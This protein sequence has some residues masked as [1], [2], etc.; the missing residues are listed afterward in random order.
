MKRNALILIVCVFLFSLQGKAEAYKASDIVMVHLQ[1]KTKYVC[2]PDRILSA[3]T[4][5]EM[6]SILYALEQKTGIETV[7][8]AVKEIEGGDCFGFAYELGK[9][10]GV[11]KKKS[12][13]GLVI[14]LST[15]ERCI[16]F[17]TG[18]GLEGILP[19]ALCKRIQE[20]YMNPDFAKGEWDT[21]MLAGIRAIN[22]CLDGSMKAE[23]LAEDDD[24]EAIIFAMVFMPCF[25]IGIFLLV[26]VQ[27]RRKSRCPRCKKH[28]LRRTDVRLISRKN[29]IKREKATY[30]CSHCGYTESRDEDSYDDSGHIGGHGRGPI[31]F[32]GGG[33]GG[34][35]GGFSGGS[36]GGGSFGGGGA[37]SRF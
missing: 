12:D 22:G 4:V 28:T 11:G 29:G 20:R 15:E 25:A 3:G 30:T 37:G 13:N 26:Y 8:V 10:N 24:T 1:D 17:V 6:D 27:Q 5:A 18:Y 34:H 9:Q 16:Q 2:N 23:D 33:F 7:V 21:G 36:F 35:G 19:D 31:I 32:G 14:L